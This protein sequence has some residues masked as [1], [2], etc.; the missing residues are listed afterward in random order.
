MKHFVS[1]NVHDQAIIDVVFEASQGAMKAIETYGEENVVNGV[2][3][4]YFREEGGLLTFDSVYRAFDKIEDFHKAR[5]AASISGSPEFQQG[6]RSWLFDS[7]GLEVPCE[8]VATPGG[9]GALSSTVKNALSPGETVIHPSI[10]W[11][12]YKTIALQHGM[13]IEHYTLFEGDRFNLDSFKSACQ[14]VMD[15]QGKV[16]AFINDP[17]QNP[18]GYTMLS[19]EWDELLDFVNDLSEKGPVILLHDIAYIDFTHLGNDYKKHFERYKHMNENVLSVIAFSASKTMTAY[20]MRIGAQVMISN[21][22]PELKRFKHACANTA[23]GVWST[24]N[25]GGMR[26]FSELALNNEVK[27]AYMQEKGEYLELLRERAKIFIREAKET[28][29]PVYPYKEGFFITLRID[30]AAVKNEL[31][32]A[33]KEHNIFF[34]NVYG[35]LRVALCSIPKDKLY[36]LAKRVKA[37]YDDVLEKHG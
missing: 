32:L 27:E 25:N 21:N 3:G 16:L 11:G 14:K 36:G 10:G 30:N 19:S 23:R 24:V 12:P 1:E 18:T 29:L 2:F 31:H 9:T 35:G 15:K 17:C 34:V 26:L 28:E 22:E 6:V 5:Y 33:L 37:V 20:G 4:A 7:A 8:I 13:K